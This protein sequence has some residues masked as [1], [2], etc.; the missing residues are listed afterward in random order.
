MKKVISLIFTLSVFSSFLFAKTDLSTIKKY[1]VDTLYS[2]IKNNDADVIAAVKNKKV[3]LNQEN[4]LGYTVLSYAA[5]DNNIE[6]VQLLLESGA[7]PDAGVNF[8]LYEVC[9]AS[10]KYTSRYEVINLLLQYGANVNKKHKNTSLTP[11]MA[12][13]KNQHGE[14]ALYLLKKGAKINAVNSDGET[15]LM[16]AIDYKDR[17]TDLVLIRTLISQGAD[18]NVIAKNGN[19][20]LSIAC[21]NGDDAIVK[22]L[23]ENHASTAIGPKNKNEI[24]VL[25]A[26]YAGSMECVELLL[27]Y[28]ADINV[29]D[30]YGS[31]ALL[32]SCVTKDNPEL[33]KL[34]LD[35]GADVNYVDPSSGHTAFILA[36]IWNHPKQ[37]DVLFANGAKSSYVNP[38]IGDTLMF[39]IG[40][41]NKESNPPFY[42]ANEL[43]GAIHGIE[44]GMFHPLAYSQSTNNTNP[45]RYA[46]SE[47]N[48]AKT[49]A[50]QDEFMELLD[51]I[52]VYSY[53]GSAQYSLHEAVVLNKV[54]VV[55]AYL[56]SKSTFIEAVDVEG[57]SAL[58]YAKKYQRTEIE[59]LLTAAGATR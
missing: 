8:P 6:I 4:V 42:P 41:G 7:K 54:D 21:Y 17:P 26:C 58:E 33:V 19:T 56:S 14:Y 15:P 40:N 34:C 22:I 1:S 11:L 27:K 52:I 25:N 37:M 30:S 13:I 32:M 59:K 49:K 23:L 47:L 9:W 18:V 46:L 48:K 44:N 10:Q 24:P 51:T 2:K 28:G 36:A 45:R 50:K 43:G 38:E 3:N 57:Y 16:L 5:I 31:S 20:A 12:T 29:K 53:K 55:K 39:I 35:Y